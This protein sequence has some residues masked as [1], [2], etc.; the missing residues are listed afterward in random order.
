MLEL[1][2]VMRVTKKRSHHGKH[3][4][5]EHPWAGDP[6]RA[7]RPCLNFIRAIGP[8]G[9]TMHRAC[10]MY[11]L[12]CGACVRPGE[13]CLIPRSDTLGCYRLCYQCGVGYL[14]AEGI[15]TEAEAL[16]VP[17]WAANGPAGVL[18]AV[19]QR[20]DNRGQGGGGER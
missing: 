9:F 15:L 5:E 13:T 14:V 12:G 11:C 17:P 19:G 20:S 18:P 10:E 4:P 3:E 2:I 7:R 8:W 1:V 6:L 16:R